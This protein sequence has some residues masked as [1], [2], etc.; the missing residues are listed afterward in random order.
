VTVF[1]FGD[2]KKDSSLSYFS[3]ED[4][5][6]KFDIEADLYLVKGDVKDRIL[7]K[8]AIKFLKKKDKPFTY[9]L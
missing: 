8:G 6:L 7:K 9:F 4:S 1:V 5:I 3:S 2:F